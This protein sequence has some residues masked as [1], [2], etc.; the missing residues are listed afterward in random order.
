M[1]W[2]WILILG[3]L[4]GCAEEE[5]VHS[6]GAELEFPGGKQILFLRRCRTR[7]ISP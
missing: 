7:P 6:E 1:R 2:M 4:L 3:S 5:P